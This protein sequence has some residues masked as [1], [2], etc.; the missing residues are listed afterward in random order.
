MF[1]TTGY[2]SYYNVETQAFGHISR[3]FSSIYLFSRMT[4]LAQVIE[5]VAEVF[6]IAE[7][8]TRLFLSVANFP[9]ALSTSIP[10]KLLGSWNFPDACSHIAI[11]FPV[12]HHAPFVFQILVFF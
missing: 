3:Y 4:K 2:L 12:A 7:L 10:F 11:T 9:T 6:C 5:S 1:S 8:V